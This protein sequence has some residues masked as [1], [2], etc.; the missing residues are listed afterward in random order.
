MQQCPRSL[1]FITTENIE[2]ASHAGYTSAFDSTGRNARSFRSNTDHKGIIS[3]TKRLQGETNTMETYDVIICG[4]GPA[5]LAAAI[6]SGRAMQKTLVLDKQ[7]AGGQALVTDD[8]AN[9]PGFPDGIS[10]F[11][12]TDRLVAHA[13][14]FG[15]ETKIEE[16]TDIKV[17]GD[18]RIVSTTSGVY[19][20]LAIIIASGSAP[21]KLGAPGEEE[22]RG[23]G[24]SYCAT[25]DGAFFKDQLTMVI[26]GGDAALKE[27]LFLTRYAREVILVH[28]RQGF[29]AERIYQD[30]VKKHP[31]IR[32]ILDAVV[33][34]ING[35]PKVSSATVRNVKTEEVTDVPC[36][37]VFIFVGSSPNTG[38]LGNLFPDLVGKHIPTNMSMET[39]IPRIYAAGDVR[40]GSY[41][42]IATGVGE[43]VTAA[44]AAEHAISELQA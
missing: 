14:K 40:E 4:A 8:I 9:L 29:R 43:G 20:A 31:Q 16:V 37:G 24:V 7:Y 33:D 42:Q 36:D 30:Q 17:D 1:L 27:A 32:L 15:A 25:C 34:K 19:R 35:D 39:T 23:K 3:R 5:G 10:G 6:Y 38:F 21:R 12:L 13:E 18:W 41:R 11:D 22:L 44:L 26:G 28:R 2:W